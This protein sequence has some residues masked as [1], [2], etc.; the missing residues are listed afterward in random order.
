MTDDGA[1]AGATV[2]LH[3]IDTG[4][5]TDASL[6]PLVLLHG[7]GASGLD[8]ES[9]VPEFAPLCRVIIPDLRGFG[10]SPRG[11]TYSVEAFAADVWAALDR[12]GIDSFNLIGHSMGG[13]V[14]LRMAVDRPDRIRRL[15]LADTLPSFV[16]DT[17]GKYMFYL[18]RLVMMHVFGPKRLAGAVAGKLF[19]K[20]EHAEL[21]ARMAARNTLHDREVY[22][23]TIQALKNWSVADR[24]D[25]LT[26]PVLVL[27]AETDYFPR[28]DVEKFVDALQYG[29]LCVFPDTH[30][31]LPL[32]VPEQFNAAVL[33]FL[34]GE[35]G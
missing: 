14:A 29:R 25:A 13:A 19:P 32:E 23:R 22:L 7:I 12:L 8:W 24:L 27:A 10:R 5:P 16:I 35:T 30:H 2:T 11:D 17:F 21:R 28:T 26:M 15:V 20:P 1:T 9:Q 18:Y 31:H 34:R 4:E 3:L 6:P 33:E